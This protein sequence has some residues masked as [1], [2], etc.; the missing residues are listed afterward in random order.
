MQKSIFTLGVFSMLTLN[1]SAQ[2]TES[3]KKSV[4][5]F[6]LTS[7]NNIIIKAV[8]N[9]QDSVK[10]MF[11][12]AATDVSLIESAVQRLKSI[13]INGTVDSVKSWGGD[14]STSDFSLRNI[15]KIGEIEKDSIT[16][17]KDK[18]SGQE[19]DGKF[20]MDFFEN[21]VVEVDFDKSVMTI[22]NALPKKLRKYTK[23][24]LNVVD[25]NYL[26]IQAICQ[27]E[28]GNFE[29]S[30]L[31]HTG[32]AGDIL[33]DDKFVS[34]NNIGQQIKITGERKLKDA[35]GNTLISKKGILPYFK[36]G[37]FQ[38]AN[39]PI[40][41]LEGTKGIQKM[42]FVGGD[43]LKRFNWIIDAKR[44]FIYLKPNGLFNTNFSTI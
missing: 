6:R 28:K 21:K 2:K 18:N 13:K 34:E 33:L 27:T 31:L 35:F 3:N 44:E 11:H 15:L 14:A 5:P 23:F 41:F 12:T 42:S 36:I 24:K 43:I 10:L 20:G 29:N 17:W 26:F 1:V 19:S 30:F 4:I 7:Y 22:Q 16:I 32:Y 40:G 39:V 37:D 38:L 9:S 8:L 25:G